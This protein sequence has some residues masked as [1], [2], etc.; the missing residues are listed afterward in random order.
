MNTKK[1]LTNLALNLTKEGK[2]HSVKSLH[3]QLTLLI[4]QGKSD[5]LVTVHG[6][7]MCSPLEYIQLE[8]DMRYLPQF[9][10]AGDVYDESHLEQEDL[11]NSI[12]CILLYALK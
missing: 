8:D 10:D 5:L 4:A 2:A 1:A 3:D 6:P 7:G 9:E 11:D 12:P